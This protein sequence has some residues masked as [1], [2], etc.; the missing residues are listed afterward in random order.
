VIKAVIIDDETA[1]RQVLSG[2]I[3]EFISDVEIIGFAGSVEEG[4]EL[5]QKLQPQLVF[6]DIRLPD[7]DG[8]E[9][10]EKAGNLSFEVIFTT[11]YSDFREK[12]FDHFALNYLTKP[13]DLD[14][15]EKTIEKF[16]NRL[17]PS[18][19]PEKISKLK[20]YVP[21]LSGK[22]ALPGKD[23]Y[24]IVEISE[25]IRCEGISNYSKVI[26]R[27]GTSLIVAKTLKHFEEMLGRHGFYRLHKSHLVNTSSIK[28]VKTDGTVLLSNSDKV[29]VSQRSK[30][31]FL[32]FL[33]GG[34]DV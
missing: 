24:V 14:K 34:N 29:F 9:I 21:Q 7:G 5:I 33:H 16:K 17:T 12:A 1:A 28:E 4:S 2:L 26:L 18:I 30:K 20:S 27:D 22:I 32:E 8:F 19:D 31:D 25:I 11:A 3:S 10:L 6:L 13:I 23:G 15:L